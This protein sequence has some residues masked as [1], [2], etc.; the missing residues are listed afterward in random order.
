MSPPTG[1][2]P[3]PA[4]RTPSTAR[5]HSETV[6]RHP[7]PDPAG[8]GDATTIPAPILRSILSE[9]LATFRDEVELDQLLRAERAERDSVR[10]LGRW[11][12]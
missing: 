1:R 6:N 7:T 8:A 5:H 11:L 4:G 10:E 12:R 2:G 9:Y 3:T